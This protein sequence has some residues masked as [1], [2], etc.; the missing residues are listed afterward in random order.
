MAKSYRDFKELDLNRDE[1]ERLTEALKDKNFRNLL[2]EYVDE[3]RNPENQKLFQEE[4]TQ[5]EKE[6]GIDVTFINPVPG[7]V[8]KTSVDGNRKAF[9]NVCANANVSKPFSS[10]GEQDGTQGRHWTIP[11]ILAPPREDYDK[12]MVRCQVF[13]VVFHPETL[14][15]AGKVRAFRDMVN[16]TACD[17]IEKN[18]GVYLDQKNFRFPKIQFKGMTHPTVIRKPSKDSPPEFSAEEKA[19]MD[20]FYSKADVNYSQARKIPTSPR[21]NKNDDPNS[22]YSTPTYLIKHRR[23]VEMEEFVDHNESKMNLAIPKELVIEIDLPLL[24][25][26]TDVVLDVSEKSLQLTSETPAKYNLFIT[27]PYCCNHDSG[28]AKFL[29]DKKKLIVTLPVILKQKHPFAADIT[30]D[31]SGVESD[32]GFSS[33]SPTEN[34]EPK[35]ND[36]F[37]FLE[38][39]VP[40]GLPDFTVH[41]HSNMLSVTLNVKNIDT[42][43][44]EKFIESCGFHLKFNSISSGFYPTHYAFYFKLLHHKLAIDTFAIEPWD[45]NVVVQI[46]IC[47]S[48]MP[49]HSYFYGIDRSDL[50][51]TD[52]V[53][54]LLIQDN[55]TAEV[56][57]NEFDKAEEEPCRP[58]PSIPATSHS[59]SSGDEIS[60]SCSPCKSKGILKGLAK[61]RQFGRSISE[62]GLDEVRELNI[63]T[64]R[65]SV[66]PE[67]QE[68][69]TSLKKT[70]RF[71]DVVSRQLFRSNSTILEQR[72]KKNWR[73]KAKKRAQRR[74]HS[75]S[76]VADA[77]SKTEYTSCS[78]SSDS[79]NDIFHLEMN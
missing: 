58:T 60:A 43:S 62:S 33:I 50:T 71:N 65:D 56:V 44:I 67:E 29:K 20:E 48:E 30:K 49:L 69:S 11:H 35:T 39:T 63:E 26:S 64:S 4:I 52:F 31:D 27:L 47:S 12:K 25:S 66:I 15:L 16:K 77:G 24:R 74:R 76:E 5:L 53:E 7:Y 70:V 2:T 37:T 18:F 23:H 72:R 55:N 73:A 59:E 22:S 6:R 68:V 51:K 75:E 3:V 46:R 57:E 36:T 19:I 61:F 10:V 17:A 14:Q 78:N 8:I 41:V 79:N 28:N 34:L 32:P 42:G 40:Y 13:D 45:N 21:K 54:P 9:V 38:P 1:V